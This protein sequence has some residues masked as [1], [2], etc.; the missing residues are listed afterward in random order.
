V[1]VDTVNDNQGYAV[2]CQLQAGTACGQRVSACVDNC[3]VGGGAHDELANQA[4][5]P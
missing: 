3:M 2:K 4:A 5:R 1:Y